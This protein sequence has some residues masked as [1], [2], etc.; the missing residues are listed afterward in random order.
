MFGQITDLLSTLDGELIY[1]MLLSLLALSALIS[2]L[3]ASSKK[4]SIEVRRLQIG[5][6]L[7]FLAQII[8]FG[9]TWLAWLGLIEAHFI[10]PPLDRSLAFFSLILIIWMWAFPTA[11]KFADALFIILEILIITIAG[12]GGSILW[13]FR[14]S[15]VLFNATLFGGYAYYIGL[16]FIILGLILLFVRRARYWGYGVLMLFILFGGYMG[17][18]S[19]RPSNLDYS[20]FIHLGEIISFL[21]LMVLPARLVDS[22]SVSKVVEGEQLSRPVETDEETGLITVLINLLTE[23]T[24]Q[25]YY[26][27]LT[28]AVALFMDADA[29]LLVLPPKTNEQLVIPLGYNRLDAQVIDGFTID[30]RSIPLTLKAIRNKEPLL[31]VASQSEKEIRVL[32]DE[33]GIKQATQFIM[34]P[35]QPKGTDVIMDLIVISPPPALLWGEKDIQ[36]VTE[37]VDSLISQAGKLAKD[38]SQQ[39]GQE[40]MLQK[41][42]NAHAYADQ[43]RLEYAQLKAKY[44]SISAEVTS[45][46]T[47]EANMVELLENQKKLQEKVGQLEARNHELESLLTKR[48][49][50]MEEVDQLRH[51]LRAAL[52]DLARIPSTL[53]KS[54]QKMLEMQLST[55]KHLDDLQPT[56]LVNS[57]AQ[58]FRQPLASIT[59]YT[60][61]LLGETIG[62]LGAMQRK[63]LER[64]KASTE[65]MGLLLSE[66][67]QVM[68]IDG[69][70]VDQTVIS[71]DLKSIIDEATGSFEARLGEKNISMQLDLPRVL[72]VVRVNKD[73]LL[74]ILSNLLENAC[75]VTPSDGVI[76]LAAK[77]EQKENMLSYILISVTDQGGGVAKDDLPRV[78]QRRYKDEN[79]PIKGIGD[80]GVGLSIVKSLVDLYKGRVWVDTQGGIGSTFSVLLP[81]AEDQ[82]A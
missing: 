39:A 56:E 3:Y 11:Q 65:R 9:V 72:P 40:E 32:A 30:S 61:L 53:S 58:E 62:I 60:D 24:P 18:L 79:P 55:V 16:F 77:V 42:Q 49:P 46:A 22:R 21:L 20:G 63:F 26:Q 44:D 76:S 52:E 41:L 50:T 54:D 75:L 4:Q 71:V 8:L 2:C 78:F 66:L 70:T 28:Q 82:A 47:Q 33:L 17:Q 69:G 80:A 74:Q 36:K 68:S 23:P 13:L 38:T 7:L 64:I 45:S 5:L 10:V 19:I 37:L 27:L 81:L 29:C 31:L 34:V 51:E 15:N 12:L 43:V 14:S 1:S 35:F 25:K 57:I 59:G 67:V 73:A 6:Q 48:R